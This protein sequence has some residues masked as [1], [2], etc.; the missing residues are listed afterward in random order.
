MRCSTCGEQL[1]S[2]AVRCPTCGTARPVGHA[3]L[4]PAAVRRCPR[5]G[6]QGEGI[7]YFR[8]AG[9]VGLLVVVS[10]LTYG[11]GGLVYWLARRKHLTCPR[12]GLGWEHASRAL[13]AAGVEPE[14]V[15][16]PTADAVDEPLPSGGVKRRVL[17]AAGVILAGFLAMVGIIEAEAA[18]IAVGAAMG[19]GGSAM[20]FWG[21]RAQQERQRALMTGL[22]RKILRL[23][24]ARGGTLTVTEVAAD[25]NLSLTAAERVLTSMD[26]G[27]RVRSEI[28]REGVLYY[29]FPELLPR[30]RLASGGAPSARRAT[31]NPVMITAAPASWTAVGR[32]PSQSQAA[33]S[34]TTGTRLE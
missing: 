17:G 31:V 32:S 15:P 29:E 2:D 6:Y 33:R 16:G 12:C 23:A 3:L 25:L 4:R 9:H 28:S 5:C 22:Q 8:R 30:P 14:R 7:P 10:F 34:A 21:W 19:A 27:F 20:F 24:E 1:R 26:D 18:A 11:F 13:Q